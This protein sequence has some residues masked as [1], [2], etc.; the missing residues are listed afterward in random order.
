MM[1]VKSSDEPRSDQVQISDSQTIA[2]IKARPYKNTQTRL[3]V[4]GQHNKSGS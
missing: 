3:N 2:G 4:S 1:E